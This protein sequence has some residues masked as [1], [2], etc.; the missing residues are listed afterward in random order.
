MLAHFAMAQD[1]AHLRA[2][3]GAA[4]GTIPALMVSDIHF[5]PFHDPDRVE[6]LVYAPAEQ[7]AAILAPSSTPDEQQ[8]FAQLQQKC[9]ARGVDTP[10]PLLQSSLKQMRSGQPGARFMTVSGDLIAHAFSCRYKTLFP[11]STPEQYQDFVVKTV[12][13][14]VQQLRASFPGMP[15]YV[16]LGN[17]D[18]GCGDYR[19][20]AG[21][22]FL[23]RTREV[24]ASGLPAPEQS[25]V[26]KEF[27][28]GGYYSVTMAAPM[29]DTRLIVVNDL[30]QSPKY[31]T[32]A[33]GADSAPA[34]AEMAW[35]QSQLAQARQQKQ[36][37]WVMGHIPPGV[38]PYSTVAKF[39]DV[40]GSE[41]PEMFLASERMADLLVEYADV[42]RLGI[43]AHTHM[44]E[45]R[46]LQA[47]SD[48][49]PEH[50]VAVKLVPS[51]SPVDGNNPSFTVAHVDAA[52]ALMNDYEVIAS[53][54]KGGT[55]AWASE[56]DY[57]RAYHQTEY[58][59][60]ALKQLIANFEDDRSGKAGISQQY[61]N[62]YFVGTKIPELKPFWPQYACSLANYTAK[63]YA[64]CVCA[65]R[66]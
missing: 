62:D 64:A 19:L 58:S 33:G 37:V 6:K 2:N 4:D 26:S 35:L 5:D 61:M 50:S 9:H 12:S 43:F 49:S 14:V 34:A 28:A 59:P 3:S 55:G 20:D 15:V 52:T 18:T 23:S 22:S 66:K 36:R 38:N 63:G 30:F 31:E 54:D 41:G 39:R 51:I 40:C 17:N 42:V 56:Y 16:A 11:S 21:G 32:C 29:R 60:V 7:W 13:F 24:V 44:D 57:A 48:A 25:R 53:P 10:Y 46:L 47:G 27:A 8:A 65:K 45:M 1:P